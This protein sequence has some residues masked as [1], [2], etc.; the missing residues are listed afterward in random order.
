MIFCLNKKN[1][2]SSIKAEIRCC[3]EKNVKKKWFFVFHTLDKKTVELHM[4][5]YLGTTLKKLAKKTMLH[6]SEILV[7]VFW[8][9][10]VL[11]ADH[12]I[13]FFFNML[14]IIYLWVFKNYYFFLNLCIFYK[15]GKTLLC[16]K[17]IWT[18]KV[19]FF[20]TS[21]IRLLLVFEIRRFLEGRA[22]ICPAE[23]YDRWWVKRD[24][25]NRW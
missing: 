5:Y 20:H 16:R 22:K 10:W 9:F 12:K 21:V 2:A 11:C 6:T 19:I 18:K 8:I 24:W 3:S 4:L 14:P 15:G 7:S 1:S 25:K 13:L 23:H 17:P